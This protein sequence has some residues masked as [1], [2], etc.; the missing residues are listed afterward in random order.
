[1]LEKG[2]DRQTDGQTGGQTLDRCMTPTDQ[3]SQRKKTKNK[4]TK[5]LVT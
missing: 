4:K 1:M 5:N 2:W 3:G